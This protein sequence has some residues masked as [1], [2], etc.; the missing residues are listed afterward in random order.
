MAVVR[1]HPDPVPRRDAL[2]KNP[3]FV[4]YYKDE[5]TSAPL[6]SHF[7]TTKPRSPRHS[8]PRLDRLVPSQGLEWRLRKASCAALPGDRRGA[9][10]GS[11]SRAP[12]L[13]LT[14]PN[15]AN[16]NGQHLGYKNFFPYTDF[17]LSSLLS[18][19]LCVGARCVHVG[20]FY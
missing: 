7:A 18:T 6:H 17:I 1:F 10:E 13:E 9:K 8:R 11:A 5:Y 12:R 14:S 15:F 2:V 4:L 3:N 19:P 20:H 16:A